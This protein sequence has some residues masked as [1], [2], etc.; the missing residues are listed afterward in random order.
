M[1]NAGNK[2]AIAARIEDRLKA[3]GLSAAAASLK[4][5]L[6]RFAIQNI[7]RDAELV[8]R[9]ST[10]LALAKALDTTP[11]YLLSGTEPD[12][13]E[14]E[15]PGGVRYGGI[16]EA[17]TF[18]HNDSTNQD[19]EFRVI[20]IAPDPRYPA[21]SQFAF[22]VMGDSMEEAGL[23]Q[24]MWV[25]AVDAHAWER[26]HGEPGDGRLVIVARIRNGDS[27]RE[28]TVKRLRLFRDRLELQPQSKNPVHKP[29]VSPFPLKEEDQEWTV[30]AV[31]ISA[32]WLFV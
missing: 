19:A 31:V 16:V 30:Q 24:G 1:L 26:L 23:I 12:E 6:S 14:A 20:P 29:F 15:R 18:R 7:L 3:L 11:E 2:S 10:L 21:A 17:G 8:P 22:E 27:E 13:Q 28:L 32:S 25:L 5:G 4:A 9:G